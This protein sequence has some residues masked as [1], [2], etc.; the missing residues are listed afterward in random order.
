MKNKLKKILAWI[1]KKNEFTF[2]AVL[3]VLIWYGIPPIF[4]L[5]YPEAG[6]FSIEVLYPALIAGIYFFIGLLF[7]WSYIGLT[8]PKGYKILDQVFDETDKITTW[9]KLQLLLRLFACLVALYAVS[10]L[11]VTGISYIM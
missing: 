8:W 3:I 9:E 7:I 1:R 4:R 2:I 10:L 11:A 5:M 6:E